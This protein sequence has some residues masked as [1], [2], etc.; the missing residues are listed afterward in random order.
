MHSGVAG[1]PTV[2]HGAEQV[3]LIQL[4]PAEDIVTAH[5]VHAPFWKNWLIDR[6]VS[7]VSFHRAS[8]QELSC[9]DSLLNTAELGGPADRAHVVG[10]APMTAEGTPS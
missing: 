9:H 6:H 4:R 2:V 10:G 1:H 3:V 7:R 5:Q 8:S